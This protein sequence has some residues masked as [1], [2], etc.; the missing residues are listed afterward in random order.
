MEISKS[1][2]K[3][4]ALELFR[5]VEADGERI[6][7]TDRGTP[8]LEVRRYVD[9]TRAPLEVLRGTVVRYDRPTDP[10]ADDDWDALR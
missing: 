3:S 8:T 7:V 5:R 2:F 9:R 10:V 1:Q 4:K 6:V